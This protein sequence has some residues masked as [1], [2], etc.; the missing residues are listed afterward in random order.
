MALAGLMFWAHDLLRS[1]GGFHGI[2]SGFAPLESCAF[3]S[4]WQ[5]YLERT[6]FD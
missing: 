2:A 1:V 6:H 5:Q 3:Q 4:T